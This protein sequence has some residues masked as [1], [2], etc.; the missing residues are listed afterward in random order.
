MDCRHLKDYAGKQA[1]TMLFRHI[2]EP[3]A[4]K[5]ASAG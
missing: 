1:A 2:L 5:E 4:P 3:R